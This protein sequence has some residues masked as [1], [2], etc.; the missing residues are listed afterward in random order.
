MFTMH[1]LSYVYCQRVQVINVTFAIPL[2][3]WSQGKHCKSAK[4]SKM[5]NNGHRAVSCGEHIIPSLMH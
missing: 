5:K 2:T 4:L 1:V 3:N